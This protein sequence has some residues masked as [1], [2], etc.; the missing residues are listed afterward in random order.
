MTAA[1]LVK[2]KEEI[3]IPTSTLWPFTEIHF[4]LAITNWFYVTR[5]STTRSHLKLTIVKPAKKPW[6]RLPIKNHGSAL[7]KN[8]LF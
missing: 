3:L 5:T 7:N 1:L 8:T 2:L 6:I 4:V